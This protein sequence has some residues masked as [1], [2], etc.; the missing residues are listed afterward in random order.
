MSFVLL[1]QGIIEKNIFYCTI[2]ATRTIIAIDLETGEASEV[3]DDN[4]VG[5]EVFYD[6]LKVNNSIVAFSDWGNTI[7]KY[8][9]VTN[10]YIRTRIGDDI[11]LGVFGSF[12]F[13]EMI[14]IFSCRQGFVYKI[15][16]STMRIE[17][18]IFIYN[19]ESAKQICARAELCENKLFIPGGETGKIF[20]LDLLSDLVDEYAASDENESITTIASDGEVLYVSG[21]D[22]ATIKKYFFRNNKLILDREITFPQSVKNNRMFSQFVVCE[23]YIIAF[24]TYDSEILTIY[25]DGTTKIYKESQK[26]AKQLEEWVARYQVLALKEE[27]ILVEDIGLERYFWFDLN[28]L[29]VEEFEINFTKELMKK[30]WNKEIYREMSFVSLDGFIKYAI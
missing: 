21:S 10:K 19:P 25:N 15:D 11:S 28:K 7:T 17:K 14:Y 16:Y 1:N 6:C 27:K 3:F 12:I 26:C 2:N 23:N 13:N 22:N 29:I 4:Y 30:C 20:V 5:E 18:K 24:P 9:S 8:D